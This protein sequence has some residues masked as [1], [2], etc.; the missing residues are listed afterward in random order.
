MRV[1]LSTGR[2]SESQTN[3]AGDVIDLPDTDARRLIETEQAVLIP[4][5]STAPD[6][7]PITIARKRGRP[8]KVESR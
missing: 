3:F 6:P 1:M 2:A 4:A 5:E 8:A 7:L